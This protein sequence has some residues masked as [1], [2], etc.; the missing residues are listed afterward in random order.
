MVDLETK[1][2]FQMLNTLNT[3][4]FASPEFWKKKLF[5]FGSF[6]P[7]KSPWKFPLHKYI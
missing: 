3:F 7:I 4:H 5:I 2:V 1:N 6:F